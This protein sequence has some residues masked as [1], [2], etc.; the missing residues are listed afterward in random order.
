M[1]KLSKIALFVCFLIAVGFKSYAQ[2]D[3]ERALLKQLVHENKQTV[4]AISMYPHDVRKDIFTAAEY[5]EVIVKLDAMQKRTQQEFTDLLAPFSKDEQE[6]IW[7]LTRYPGLIADIA[8]G[9]QK[10]E[11]EMNGILANFPDE[12]HKTAIE[13]N[14]KNYDLLVKIDGRNKLYTIAFNTILDGYSPDAVAAFNDL[15]KQPEIFNILSDNMQLTILIGDFYKKQPD[16]VM[17]KSDSANAALTALNAQEAADWKQS[18]DN[19]PEAKQEY[20]DAAQQYAQDNG[21]SADDYNTPLN[22]DVTDYYSNSYNWWF[23]YPY[24]YPYAYW[25]PYPYWY[26]WG[27][28]YGP[29]GSYVFFGLPSPWFM[30]WYYYYPE[31]HHRWCHLSSHYYDYYTRHRESIN[32]NSISRYTN[33]WRENNRG[34]ISK[35]WDDPAK[36]PELFKEY[37]QMETNRDKYNKE[38]PKHQMDRVEYVQKYDNKYPTI[39]TAIANRTPEEIKAY[40]KPVVNDI[41]T[42]QKEPVVKIPDYYKAPSERTP[43]QNQGNYQQPAQQHYTAPKPRENPVQ[44]RNAEQYHQNNWNQVQPSRTTP[45]RQPAPSYTPQP[46]HTPSTPMPSGG[47]GAGGVRRK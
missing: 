2:D 28:Y 23:G 27:F 45:S 43:V 19:D 13:E 12:I 41:Q 34:V 44:M 47:N 4:D 20:V 24:W 18:L 22:P 16:Y 38:N 30:N 37:G 10:T 14:S 33:N 26:D 3:D 8:A 9:H 29:G 31:H 7:N 36:R 40:N 11:E 1:K 32:N 35:E 25:D 15:V 6:K 39:K 17:H 46:S 5:P 21:Y 42:P